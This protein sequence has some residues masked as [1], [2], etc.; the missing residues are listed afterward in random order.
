MLAQFLPEEG[1]RPRQRRRRTTRC[2]H[3]RLAPPR[4]CPTAGRGA[5]LCLPLR[6]SRVRRRRPGERRHGQGGP[7]AVRG[8][9][10][11]AARGDPAYSRPYRLPVRT[12]ELEQGR[13]MLAAPARDGSRLPELPHS[14]RAPG[15]APS[16][17]GV[18][19][20]E[21]PGTGS[22]RLSGYGGP[23][24]AVAPVACAGTQSGGVATE[25]V[26]Q[27]G[28]VPAAHGVHFELMLRH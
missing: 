8:K 23:G 19:R 20:I 1:L 3:P 12:A 17:A 9:P 22:D 24:L 26:L 7:G 16:V 27:P 11:P 18:K 5:I 25:A 2:S 15:E 21:G 10:S 4:P 13:R 14:G 6:L 28:V